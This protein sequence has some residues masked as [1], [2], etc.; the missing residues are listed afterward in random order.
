MIEVH[1]SQNYFFKSKYKN[2]SQESHYHKESL[3]WKGLLKYPENHIFKICMS[4]CTFWNI[5][6]V[7]KLIGIKI[8]VFTYNG[9]PFF[10]FF[11]GISSSNSSF[12]DFLF[13]F[14]F[15]LSVKEKVII[16]YLSLLFAC[17]KI[18]FLFTK[19]YFIV[20]SKWFL[21]NAKWVIFQLY[22]GENKL[23]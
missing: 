20:I 12:I 10:F 9:C 11:R 19:Q 14:S 21:L 18:V 17:N 13:F 15:P 23:H 1:I 7:C 8:F 4:T 3:F 5:T 6:T 22:H 2:L 16:K